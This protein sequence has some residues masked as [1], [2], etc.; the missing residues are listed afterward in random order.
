MRTLSRKTSIVNN[1][2]KIVE[3]VKIL[4]CNSYSR[5]NAPDVMKWSTSP[6]N[7]T[8]AF[9]GRESDPA[10]YKHVKYQNSDTG[11]P[12]MLAHHS[13]RPSNNPDNT[14]I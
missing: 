2:K 3:E 7:Q 12:Q 13:S 4:A 9:A 6:D 1:P 14:E 5:Q 11:W 10:T 8:S